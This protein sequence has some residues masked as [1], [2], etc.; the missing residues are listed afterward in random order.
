MFPRGV[1]LE[2]RKAPSLK[3]KILPVPGPEWIPAPK[4]IAPIRKKPAP[5]RVL[6]SAQEAGIVDE[7]D[8]TPLEKKLSRFAEAGVGTLVACCFDNDP[9]TSAGMA[10][11][12]EES[13]AVEDG[14]ALAALACGASNVKIAAASRSEALRARKN[15]VKTRILIAPQR[16]PAGTLLRGRLNTE[17]EK[18]GLVGA[19]A[20]AALSAAVRSGRVQSDTV[21]TVA[22][23]AVR[24]WVNCRVR[25]GTPLHCLLE[26]G[27][28]EESI[29]AVVVGSS[30]TGKTVTDLSLPAAADTRCVIALKKLPKACVFPCVGCG[31]CRRACP[32]GV[33]PWMVLR[34]IGKE[35]PDPFRMFNVQHCD[36]CA[37]CSAVCPSGIDLVGTVARAARF[38]ESGVSHDAE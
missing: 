35:D 37:A 10:V 26:A 23:D 14:L 9:F 30:L 4:F 38:K 31:R 2:Q 1:K 8:G 24:H 11:L 18:A 12:R 3:D 22:G 16:Y 33:I 13:Q 17:G 28:A 19:Q 6:Q 36:G 21:V 15:G 7:L 27:K 25:I 34:E 29:A 32:R 5:A 20:C